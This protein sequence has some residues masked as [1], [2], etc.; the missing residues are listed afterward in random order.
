MQ[1][2]LTVC[3]ACSVPLAS[4]PQLRLALAAYSYLCALLHQADPLIAAARSPQTATCANE[5]DTEHRRQQVLL[6]QQLEH[7]FEQSG[8]PQALPAAF[9]AITA[10]LQ[11]AATEA[12]VAQLSGCSSSSSTDHGSSGSTSSWVEE[13][14]SYIGLLILADDMLHTYLQ[15]SVCPGTKLSVGPETIAAAV[16]LALAA[17]QHCDWA[18]TQGLGPLQPPKQQQQQ[19]QQRSSQLWPFYG[20]LASLSSG[21]LMMA[22]STAHRAGALSCLW[23][24]PRLQ[25]AASLAAVVGGYIRLLSKLAPAETAAASAYCSCRCWGRPSSSSGSSSS[26]D[27]SSG[28]GSSGNGGSS[29]SSSSSSW[30]TESD[31]SAEAH[32][33]WQI[34]CHYQQ[35]LPALPAALTD[36]LGVDRLLLA[37]VAV[38]D[39]VKGKAAVVVREAL[40]G[41]DVVLPDPQTSNGEAGETPS[42]QQTAREVQQQ[43]QQQPAG[44]AAAAAVSPAAPAAAAA[45]A[46]AV[47]APAKQA[48]APAGATLGFTTEQLQTLTQQMLL[49]KKLKRQ[50]M[51]AEQV[52]PQDLTACKPKPL[53]QPQQ[54]RAPCGA[55]SSAAAVAARQGAA[56]ATAAA[57]RDATSAAAAAAAGLCPQDM[58]P[59]QLDTNM[60]AP[61]GTQPQQQQ[62]GIGSDEAAVSSSTQQTAHG[63]QQ[64]QQ[65]QPL[66][67]ELYLLLAP[68]LLECAAGVEDPCTTIFRRNAHDTAVAGAGITLQRFVEDSAAVADYAMQHGLTAA[69]AAVA[70]ADP[71]G[72]RGE[73]E[74]Q[75]MVAVTPFLE[76]VLPPLLQ[77]MARKLAA[78]QAATA[79]QAAAA[80][81]AA[82]H[83]SSSSDDAVAAAMAAAFGLKYSHSVVV[84]GLML[85]HHLSQHTVVFLSSGDTQG[86]PVVRLKTIMITKAWRNN[87]PQLTALCEGYLRAVAAAA[88]TAQGSLAAAA[89]RT[90]A[91]AAAAAQGDAA[92]IAQLLQEGTWPVG[93]ISQWCSVP[94]RPPLCDPSP[95]HM[96]QLGLVGSLVKLTGCQGFIGWAAHD[97]LVARRNAAYACSSVLQYIV[98]RDA[99]QGR[100]SKEQPAAAGSPTSFPGLPWL[101][102]FGRVC[103][104]WADALKRFDPA[105]L[106]QQQQPGGAPTKVVRLLALDLQD[107]MGLPLGSVAEWLQLN[108]G[109]LAATGY[110]VQGVCQQLGVVQQRWRAACAAVQG[111]AVGQEEAVGEEAAAA[112]AA[113]AAVVVVAELAG[114][115]R[116]F[117]AAVSSALPVPHLCNNPG[118]RNVSGDSEVALVSGRS[119]IC[120]GCKVARYC[121]RSCQRACWKVHKPVCH[122]LAAAA[123]A[124]QAAGGGVHT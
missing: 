36:M 89:Q 21:V 91:A 8:L 70:T 84:Q 51:G 15:M 66:Q 99:D 41:A 46:A 73:L 82:S 124:A 97:A 14:A 76:A 34:A 59:V 58:Q 65:Q 112:A 54:H 90:Q 26:T 39:T 42:N 121:G 17:L 3:T 122:V 19:Q 74:M 60:A 33:A 1:V 44:S 6:A 55:V 77:V 105:K 7:Q 40:L 119:C 24:R 83:G 45:T 9:N 85:L 80:A 23:L 53:P 116:V 64:Q 114:S 35:Q 37:W 62:P 20:E 13:R 95:G 50:R 49:V 10:Q 92:G 72:S 11:A 98:Y 123:V 118:C 22:G 110:S 96:L 100:T 68:L 18:I 117:G 113:A 71:A 102:L 69:V 104:Q 12:V 31:D 109:V 16:D 75:R 61:V 4:A 67:H 93:L 78:V 88:A 5:Q 27:S 107:R 63:E 52:K 81:A 47:A 103:S 25:A 29:S 30:L 48:A 2:P 28:A 43:Q 111:L 56:A 87:A 101:V 115:L 79:G 120:A 32:L 108:V 106:A 86:D 94:G 57:A 38:M